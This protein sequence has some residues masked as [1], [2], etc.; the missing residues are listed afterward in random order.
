MYYYPHNAIVKWQKDVRWQPFWL[1][2]LFGWLVSASGIKLI[3]PISFQ[4]DREILVNSSSVYFQDCFEI[5]QHSL[6]GLQQKGCQI[7]YTTTIRNGTAANLALDTRRENVRQI[8]PSNSLRNPHWSLVA[9]REPQMW[10]D[11]SFNLTMK[12]YLTM[13][14]DS[15]IY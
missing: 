11:Q 10:R 9:F 12:W 15:Q 14:N 5:T 7:F 2:G 1:M 6:P 8:K 3:K 13:W 4:T